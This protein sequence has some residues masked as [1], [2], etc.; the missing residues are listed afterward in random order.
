MNKFRLKF[1]ILS[2]VL[3]TLSSGLLFYR[4]L[5]IDEIRIE[6]FSKNEIEE[7]RFLD[8]EINTAMIEMRSNFNISSDNILKNRVKITDL[9]SILLE[10]KKS[11]SEIKTKLSEV[12]LYF[13][14]KNKTIDNFLFALREIQA[15][16]KIIQATNNELQKNNI[17]FNLDGKDFYR[18]CLTDTL[19]YLISPTKNAEWKYN[20]NLKILNQIISFSKI[21]NPLIIKYENSI[22][23]IRKNS[24][25]IDAQIEKARSSNITTQVNFVLNNQINSKMLGE[26][27]G[28]SF[29]ILIFISVLIYIGT[30]Y[31]V[32][33]KL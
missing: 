11:N 21:P 19:F 25:I 24:K 1:F 15:D 6:K 9:L 14:E 29:L 7:I 33:R 17:K 26:S 23:N 4:E 12:K 31:F 30:I 20:E 28:Q 8:Q 32:M 5:F 13:Q 27:R 22:N 3:I 18:E 10:S 16:L 2:S